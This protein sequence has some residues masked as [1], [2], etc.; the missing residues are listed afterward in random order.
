MG[1]AE[2]LNDNTGEVALTNAW[3]MTLTGEEREVRQRIAKAREQGVQKGQIFV[4]P[5]QSYRDIAEEA[6]GISEP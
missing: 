3:T 1:Q 2:R 6:G 5:L 4:Y